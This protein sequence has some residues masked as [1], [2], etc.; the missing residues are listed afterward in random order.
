MKGKW[1]S[2]MFPFRAKD[3]IP[4]LNSKVNIPLKLSE[5]DVN[6]DH[7]ETLLDLAIA[8]FAHPNNTKPV[9]RENFKQLY[10]VALKVNQ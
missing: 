1:V 7:I 10:L 9:T 2:D 8:D 3:R 4:E 5:T 6:E